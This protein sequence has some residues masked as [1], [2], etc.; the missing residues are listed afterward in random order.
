ML[1]SLPLRLGPPSGEGDSSLLLPSQGL[2]EDLVEVQPHLGSVVCCIGVCLGTWEGTTSTFPSLSQLLVQTWQTS[3]AF[4]EHYRVK[5]QALCS[6]G[7]GK[8]GIVMHCSEAGWEV[9]AGT[10]K[11]LCSSEFHSCC[12]CSCLGMLKPK[13]RHGYWVP[14]WVL[15]ISVVCFLHGL[16]LWP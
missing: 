11:A 15:V 7:F 2:G 6:W 8:E 1:L 5:A 10:R 9:S 3:G 13:H 12:V 14:G 16:W 4:A